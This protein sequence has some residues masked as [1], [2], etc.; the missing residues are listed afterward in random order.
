MGEAWADSRGRSVQA[1][2]HHERGAGGQSCGLHPRRADGGRDRPAAVVDKQK[3]V[4]Y[5]VFVREKDRAACGN[6][7]AK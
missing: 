7:K 5:C 6:A 4:V 3:K 1:P 2:S